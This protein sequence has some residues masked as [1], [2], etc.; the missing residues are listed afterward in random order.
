[1]LITYKDNFI[2]ITFD[3]TY[4]PTIDRTFDLHIKQIK[5]CALKT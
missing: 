5:K 3:F 2:E 1:M 4:D